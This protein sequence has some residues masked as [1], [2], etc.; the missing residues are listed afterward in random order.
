[1]VIAIAPDGRHALVGT[2]TVGP[3]GGCGDGGPDGFALV[4]FATGAAYPITM[5][6]P[7][8]AAPGLVFAFDS[9]GHLIADEQVSDSTDNITEFLE[10]FDFRGHYLRTL[11]KFAHVADSSFTVLR[12]TT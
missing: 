11:P 4:N 1:S 12:V 6:G 8:Y 2:K 9:A 10:L 3:D 7:G 5:R